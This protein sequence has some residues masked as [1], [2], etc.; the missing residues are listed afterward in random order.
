LSGGFKY[1]PTMSAAL[2][3]N[4]GSVVT[5]QDLRPA[6]SIRWTRRKRQTYFAH[7]AQRLGQQRR[8]PAGEPRRRRAVEQRQD[9]AVGVLAVG[10]GLARARRVREPGEAVAGEPAPPLADH[11][12]GAAELAGDRPAGLP[13]D[14]EQHDPRPLDQPPV[15]LARA[16]PALQPATLR[17]RQGDRRRFLK[18]HANPLMY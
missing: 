9:A 15:R 18:R 16:A 12:A 1:K 2:A 11:A 5:H 10:L 17:R 3:A 14:R 8:G 6:K 7:V 13:G 4:S